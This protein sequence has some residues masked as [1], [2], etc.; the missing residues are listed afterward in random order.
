MSKSKVKDAVVLAANCL[1]VL[2]LLDKDWS[3]GPA[4]G[5]LIASSEQWPVAMFGRLRMR[6]GAGEDLSVLDC[7]SLPAFQRLCVVFEALCCSSL[8]ADQRPCTALYDAEVSVTAG[9]CK[10][11]NIS[12]LSVVLVCA[13]AADLL[14]GGLC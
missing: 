9:V 13:R 4:S 14:A 8:S 6:T 5:G 10:G 12:S 2:P 7:W 1:L 11:D 3:D